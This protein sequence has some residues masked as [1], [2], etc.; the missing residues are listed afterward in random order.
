MKSCKEMSTKW[1]ISERRVTQYCKEG[2]IPGAVKI[3]KHWQVPDDAKRPVDNRIV[4]GR[5][6]KT[7]KEEGKNRFL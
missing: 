2:K 1:G 3:G 5:Y 7:E 4:T 6:V